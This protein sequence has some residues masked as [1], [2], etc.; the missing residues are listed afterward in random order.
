M[1]E[2]FFC[3]Q[4]FASALLPFANFNFNNE[5]LTMGQKNHRSLA[6]RYCVYN[7]LIVRLTLAITMHVVTSRH[8]PLL[9][10][11]NSE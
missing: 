5:I 3:C 10:V 6:P 9:R 7:A 1:E 4:I 2:K 8:H 11:I